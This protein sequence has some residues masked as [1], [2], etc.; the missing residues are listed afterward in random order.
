MST[1]LCEVFMVMLHIGVK[2]AILLVIALGIVVFL[3]FMFFYNVLG[4]L[5]CIPA[6]SRFILGYADEDGNICMR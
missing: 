2:S 4:T 3:S 6:L 5:I 1:L